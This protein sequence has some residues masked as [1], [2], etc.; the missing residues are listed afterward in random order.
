MQQKGACVKEEQQTK[1]RAYSSG[2]DG[3]HTRGKRGDSM[4]GRCGSSVGEACRDQGGVPHKACHR[5]TSGRHA[6]SAPR[7]VACSAAWKAWGRRER[8]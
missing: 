4:L 2:S 3:L 6:C 5:L 1:Q 8:H 7:A